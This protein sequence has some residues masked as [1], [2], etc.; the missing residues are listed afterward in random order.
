MKT[1]PT[2]DNYVP[3]LAL[4]SSLSA[5]RLGVCL[6]LADAHGRLHSRALGLDYKSKRIL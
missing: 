1:I 3:N 4:P 5:G 2:T 6:S